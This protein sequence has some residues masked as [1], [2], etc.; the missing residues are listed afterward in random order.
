MNKQP[1]TLLERYNILFTE[2]NRA[3]HDM[4]LR[5]GLS[6]SAMHILYSLCSLGESCPLSDITCGGI[7]KQTINSALRKLEAEDIVYLES[8]GGRK[9]TVCL[10]EKGKELAD[11]TARRVIAI[12]NEIYDSWT[13]EERQVYI[14]LNRRYL[15]SLREKMKEL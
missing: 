10:T 7:S 14:D 13:A 8:S 5:L 6:D 2:T 3:Y 15:D 9:K 11:R 1:N 12:E 4:A